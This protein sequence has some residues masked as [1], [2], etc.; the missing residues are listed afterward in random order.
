MIIKEIHMQGFG[1]WRNQTLH[2]TPGINVCTA[3]NESGKTT[4]L[5]ALFASLYGMKRDYVRVTRY[6]D[7]HERY[8]PWDKGSYETVIRYSIEDQD[9][10]LHRHFSKEKEQA[11]L[12]LEPELTEVT[13]LYQE[14]RRKEY[15]FMEKHLGLT[16]SVF[17]DVTWVRSEP[18]VASERFLPAVTASYTEDPIM[19]TLLG[20]LETEIAAIGKKET[21]ENTLLGKASKQATQASQALIEAEQAWQS[22][23]T[24][25]QNVAG[26]N[27][28]LESMVRQKQQLLSLQ[29]EHERKLQ[30]AQKWWQFSFQTQTD[31]Q[32]LMW[33][34]H[35]ETVE[36]QMVHKKVRERLLAI[37]QTEATYLA[38]NTKHQAQEAEISKQMSRLLSFHDIPD[39]E[40]HTWLKNWYAYSANKEDQAE[41]TSRTNEINLE[42]L[43]SD[44]R[45]GLGLREQIEAARHSMNRTPRRMSRGQ[46]RSSIH[47]GSGNL[48][49][50]GGILASSGVVLGILL[51]G[52]LLS[53]S[54]SV[55]T[56]LFV[57]SGIASIG[58]AILLYK[59]FSS[60]KQ[61]IRL[62][63][64]TTQMEADFDPEKTAKL[65]E[66]EEH[67]YAC[68]S[69]LANI[70]AEWKVNGWE[71]FLLMREK[72]L[73]D[74]HRSELGKQLQQE[75]KRM[76]A[77]LE[78]TML[79]WGVPHHL[80]FEEGV[81]LVLQEHQLWEKRREEDQ[82]RLEQ[83]LQQ[84]RHRQQVT[85]EY[86]QVILQKKKL[87]QEWEE[88]VRTK[89][90][91][92]MQRI[93]LQK[94][95]EE[96]KLKQLEEKIVDHKEQIARAHGEIGQRDYVSWA[97]AKSASD[98]AK[99]QVSSLLKRRKA[100][101]LAQDSL[102]EAW[103]EWHRE[104]SPD[105]N[106]TASEIMDHI[107]DGRYH[108]VRLDPLHHY[109][110]RVI[111][112]GTRDVITQKQLSSG[113]QDQLYFAQRMAM[114]THCS[115]EKEP[116]P[117]FFDDHFIHYD[118]TRLE[119]TLQYVMKLAEKHQVFLF[120][121][122][123]REEKLLA[124]LMATEGRHQILRLP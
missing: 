124:P 97:Q 96:E 77:I 91:E 68:E 108:D 120:S 81:S 92:E 9:F 26:W 112:P 100:L 29:R 62:Q 64:N 45:L 55:E 10:R 8:E 38:V 28:E 119:Q 17:T 16:R 123:P 25:S 113:T 24:L 47:K 27:A 104:F 14:D 79:Q 56:A 43:Q 93:N 22:V 88:H 39:E 59:S 5:Q 122:Q 71:A 107:T 50:A 98:E 57:L 102:M 70:V 75:K 90:D 67:V 103:K 15:N 86:E 94:K 52:H 63:P 37:K 21:A 89:L 46:G 82:E 32:L 2:F 72:H 31:E 33:E 12:F 83:E 1:K 65:Q 117:I 58:G 61:N 7:E 20:G 42:K 110:I 11:R 116:L 80:S 85:Q 53:V 95:S 23:Q 106:Q 87:L 54:T 118:Q 101:E 115:Q 121:C 105:L 48:S 19:R 114:I 66:M 84:E 111:E 76:K 36:E 60:K 73:K 18:L 34:Q 49:W 35:A 69:Q 13:A 30:E 44:Y 99:E 40:W 109:A 74:I 3:P 4:L 51:L 41:E 78:K 6:L